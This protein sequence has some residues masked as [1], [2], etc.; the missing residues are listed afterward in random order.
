VIPNMLTSSTDTGT[1]RGETQILRKQ[2]E[3]E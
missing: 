2:F 1:E 3:Q